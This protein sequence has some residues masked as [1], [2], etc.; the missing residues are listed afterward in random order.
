LACQLS[1]PQEYPAAQQ[2]TVRGTWSAGLAEGGD[3]D[4]D[5]ADNDAG[6]AASGKTRRAVLLGALPGWQV[7]LLNL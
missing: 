3:M 7:S 6:A 2:Q 4:R 5:K 1:R